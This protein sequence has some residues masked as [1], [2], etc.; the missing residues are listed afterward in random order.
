[1]ES[2][3]KK[4]AEILKAFSQLP[5]D[6]RKHIQTFH[7]SER[8]YK[9]CPE[10]YVFHFPYRCHHACRGLCALLPRQTLVCV[11]SSILDRTASF[12]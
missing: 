1:M 12:V 7:K 5:K 11:Y 3:L 10:C 8:P 9:K 2:E 4:H 6:L